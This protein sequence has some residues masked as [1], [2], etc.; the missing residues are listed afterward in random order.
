MSEET[1]PTLEFKTETLSE[2]QGQQPNLMK[3]MPDESNLAIISNL[4]Q[5]HPEYSPTQFQQMISQNCEGNKEKDRIISRM[6]GF[7]PKDNEVWRRITQRFG[8]NVKQPELLSIATVLSQT[9]N[10]KLD[11]DAKRRKTV[12][13]K[14][15]QENWAAISPYLDYVVLEDNR[16]P[17]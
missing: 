15:F 12:L 9:A 8:A 11:R 4:L 6:Q 13:I 10:V 5:L 1:Q 17:Q 2:P 7:D 16:P 3:S 14:W